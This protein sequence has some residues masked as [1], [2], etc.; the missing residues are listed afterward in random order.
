M[1]PFRRLA[2]GAAALLA[3]VGTT[4]AAASASPAS[5]SPASASP[6]SAS[7]TSASWTRPEAVAKASAWL[8][9]RFTSQGYIPTSAGPSHPDLSATAQAVLSLAAANSNLSTARRG[10]SYLAAN[11][12]AYVTD[13]GADGPSQLAQLILD[14]VAL[15]GDPANFGH[16]NL[17]TRLLATAQTSGAD[18]GLFGTETQ[19]AGYAAGTYQQ[20]LAL[21]ALRAAGVGT[22]P[23]LASAVAWLQA[24]QCPDGGWTSPDQALN[25]CDGTPATFSGPDT[26][27]TALAIEGLVAEQALS[28]GAGSNA[29]S[30]LAKG[31]DADGGWSYFPNTKATPGAT[32]PDSTSLVIQ[33]LFASRH[34]VAA[35]AYSRLQS[36]QFTSGA[37]AGAF[38]FPPAPSPANIVATYQAIPAL[39]SLPV[40]FGPQGGYWLAAADGSVITVGSAAF[41]GSAAS[42]HPNRPIVGIA[43]TPDR[44]G[45]WEVGADGGIFA[46][47]DAKYRGSLPA[48]GVPATDIVGIT[49]TGDGD[50]YWLVGA[51]G[52]VFA[53]GSARFEGSLPS[54]GVHVHDI[55]GISAVPGNTGYLL[56]ASDGEVSAFGDAGGESSLPALGV[57]VSDVVG[58]VAV[59]FSGCWLVAADGGVFSLGTARFHGSMGGA[60]LAA[61]VT[62]LAATPDAGGYYEVAA[63]G[64]IFAFGDARFAGSAVGQV[65]AGQAIVGMAISPAGLPIAAS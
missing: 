62:G 11:V 28:T 36:F 46:F 58:V 17:I 3:I 31:I 57:H 63:D 47:G 26:N 23:P 13:E 53:F 45:Y 30:F 39:V 60:R 6:T 51:D 22:G 2:L 55:V 5:A 20:G 18:K 32:D 33:A 41:Y 42:A 52:G 16:T 56:T 21:A 9:S 64:G 49:A 54:R 59:G 48:L 15:G 10:L 37:D 40:P 8:A 65:R 4:S 25:G 12:E 43:V 61:P 29:Y 7:P 14:A 27:S 19:L 50:G 1:T 44:R 35:T 34:S 38:Y 24:Q